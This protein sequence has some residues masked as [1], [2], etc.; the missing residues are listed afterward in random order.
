MKAETK[1]KLM[2]WAIILLALLNISTILTILYNRN[3]AAKLR[4]YIGA[5]II[6]KCFGK[7]QRTLFQGSTGI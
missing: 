1:I 4:Q 7:I 3:Q 5:E 2:I 6:G